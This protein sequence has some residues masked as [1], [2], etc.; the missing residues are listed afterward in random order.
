M[1]HSDPGANPEAPLGA[2]RD[3]IDAVDQEVM[4][5]LIRRLE[6]VGEV[7]KLKGEHGLPI[8]APDRERSMIAARRAE[9]ERRGLSPDLI[10]DVLRRCM[11]EAY[12]H[13]KNLGFTRQAPDLGPIVI[14]GGAGQMG[15]L[16]GRMLR[17]SGY[18]VR[19]LD[20]DDWS[21]AEELLDGAGMVLVS[22]PISDTVEVLHQLPP[23]PHDCLLVDLTSTKVAPMAAMLEIHPGPVLGLHPMF[24]P[25]VD[26]LAKQ[27]V[28]YVPGR[29]PDASTWLLEQI[30]LWGARLH[31]ISAED[32]D[33]AMGLI[34][35]Q[36]H[37]ATFADGLHLVREDRSID[38]LLSLSSPIY[39]LEL[40]MIGRLFG[41]DPELYADIIMASPDNLALIERYHD[42]FA[43]ALEILRAG[44]REAFIARFREIGE[45]FGA[46]ADRFRAE[47]QSL[48]AHADAQR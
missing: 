43:E 26:N 34:Q 22:V 21:R 18:D 10:E 38:E 40:I 30:R 48:L 1:E 46:H 4:S 24:G 12:A 39:R 17:L 29:I 28:A 35:A 3:Q 11:R 41:Q 44:D 47:S 45:W 33:H 13:E 2:L 36:R 19:Q 42:R 20:R 37:F 27:V 32:H 14:V 23:L 31:E 25:D 16:F 5:L 7:G 8:Y 6:L 15:Q 9:A